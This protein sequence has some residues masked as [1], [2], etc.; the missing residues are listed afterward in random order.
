NFQKFRSVSPRNNSFGLN[1]AM[2]SFRYSAERIRATAILH[3]G[4][5]PQAVWSPVYTN[6]MDA[7][8]GVR[9]CKKIWL[10]AGFFKTHFGTESFLPKE[11]F[12]SSVSV[13]TYYEPYF[14]SGFR[15][16]YMLN[17]KLDIYLFVLNGYNMFVDN[18]KKKSFGTLFLYNLGKNGNIGY[19]SYVGD[20][21]PTAAD[22]ISHLRVQQNLFINYEIGKLKIQIGGDYCFQQHSQIGNKTGTAS[23]FS[24]VASAKYQLMNKFAA[25]GR[26]EIFNDPQGFMSQVITDANGFLTGYKLWGITA[27]IE[28]QP[29][30]NSYIRLEGRQIQMD[31]AQKIFRW[32]G[33]NRTYRSEILLNTGISF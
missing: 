31:A 5:I 29:T 16:N 19:S 33:E 18:N 26:G 1:T 8:A 25:Y 2:F 3:F 9:L 13:N 6:V 23:M 17:D 24:G 15:I 4:D 14:E 21:T 10:D 20:D 28:Y 30:E 7:H 12:T 32:N 22:S 27:G 11:N